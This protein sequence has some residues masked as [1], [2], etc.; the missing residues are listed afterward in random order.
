MRVHNLPVQFHQLHGKLFKFVESSHSLLLG[1]ILP[2]CLYKEVVIHAQST[3]KSIEGGQLVNENT[4]VFIYDEH[5]ERL[6][7]YEIFD[8][9]CFVKGLRLVEHRKES[10][11]FSRIKPH[12]IA[13]HSRIQFRRSPAT[14]EIFF[15]NKMD[16][17]DLYYCRK[18]FYLWHTDFGGVTCSMH[19]A[20]VYMHNVSCECR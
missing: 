13:V 19:M 16:L 20:R 12:Y 4:S 3:V 10:G 8:E 5:L 11:V 2:E 1:E 6:S 15:H 14:V 9:R 7:E 18:Q 17:V